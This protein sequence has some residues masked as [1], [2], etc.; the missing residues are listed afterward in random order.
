MKVFHCDHCG[1]LLFFENFHC[2]HCDHLLAYVPEMGVV[3][4]LDPAGN[5]EWTSPLPRA[6]GKKFRLCQ[7]FISHNTCNWAMASEDPNALCQS[8]RLTRTIPNLD[9][10]QNAILWYRMGIAKRRL[11]YTL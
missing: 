2:V 3:C 7:N 4:S 9:D 8:C 11:I 5:D 6:A 1:Q 10:H